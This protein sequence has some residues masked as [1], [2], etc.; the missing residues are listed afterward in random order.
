MKAPARI[1]KFQITSFLKNFLIGL[2]VAMGV[3]I[4]VLGISKLNSNFHL[5]PEGFL[6]ITLISVLAIMSI[7]FITIQ[8][9]MGFFEDFRLAT[10]LGITRKNFFVSNLVFMLVLAIVFSLIASGIINYGIKDKGIYIDGIII[11]EILPTIEEL[12]LEAYEGIP[13]EEIKD[14]LE[15]R[16]QEYYNVS[17]FEVFKNVFVGILGVIGFWTIIGLSVF[18]FGIKSLIIIVPFIA[19]SGNDYVNQIF[20]SQVLLIII[21]IISQIYVYLGIQKA[22]S[23]V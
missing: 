4:I 23:V 12:D 14:K 10:R 11:E 16:A 15:E 5:S 9:F 8:C 21:Y 1:F 22:D 19:L 2:L 13:K 17:Y 20:D 7:V 3:M 18:L 6:P